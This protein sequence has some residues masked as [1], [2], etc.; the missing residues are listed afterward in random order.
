VCSAVKTKTLTA[1]MP[2]FIDF[3]KRKKTFSVVNCRYVG[4]FLTEL[5]LLVIAIS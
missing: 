1:Y 4:Y 2:L 5:A 3:E